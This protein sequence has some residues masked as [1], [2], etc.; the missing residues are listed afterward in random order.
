[1]YTNSNIHTHIYY[2]YIEV[3]TNNSYTI[4]KLKKFLH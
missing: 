4:L 3:A 2:K 1:M